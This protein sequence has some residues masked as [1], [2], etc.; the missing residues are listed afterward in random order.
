MQKLSDCHIF[1]GMDA[2]TVEAIT[3]VLF[4]VEVDS[5]ETLFTQ[6]AEGTSL[7][8]VLDGLFELVQAT[9]GGEIHLADVQPG[10][11][12]GLTSLIDPGPR[13]AT[14]RAMDDGVVVR[15][16]K[17][18]PLSLAYGQLRRTGN[19]MT[20]VGNALGQID[21]CMQGDAAAKLHYQLAL[22]AIEEVRSANRKLMELLDA[23]LPE[24]V[25]EHVRRLL[26]ALDSKIYQAGSFR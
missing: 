24:R 25:P 7:V 8:I 17:K 20:G 6:G 15:R 23:P 1:R 11:V 5:G 4:R 12:I 14:L 22:I 21:S 26:P 10:R 19:F 16:K 2:R 13:T 3:Q 18:P 9:E